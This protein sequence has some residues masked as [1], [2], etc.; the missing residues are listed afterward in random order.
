MAKLLRSF[1][2]FTH[3][4]DLAVNSLYDP[5]TGEVAAFEELVGSHGGMGGPQNEPFIVYPASWASGEIEIT[6]SNDLHW[7]LR[8]WQQHLV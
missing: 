3:V 1:D 2:T 6:N 5:L 4:P 8:R 7:L